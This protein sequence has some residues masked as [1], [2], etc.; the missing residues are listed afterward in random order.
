[1][2]QDGLDVRVNFLRDRNGAS[3]VELALVLPAV[4]ALL[5]GFFNGC[6][7]YWGQTAL[8]YAVDDAARCWSIGLICTS[9]GATTGTPSAANPV[10]PG[11]FAQYYYHGPKINSLTF[12]TTA[13]PTP[14][15]S[16]DL[17][18]EEGQ[19]GG[20]CQAPGA[21]NTSTTSVPGYI[22]SGSGTYKFDGGIVRFNVPISATA[23]FPQF[24]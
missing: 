9:G 7:M 17:S 16:K 3:A 19:A 8:H 20:Y 24:S 10:T 14:T 11:Y 15:N 6:A 12:T 4:A 21:S 5:I 18:T 13:P 2:D 1:M 23:C 22:V